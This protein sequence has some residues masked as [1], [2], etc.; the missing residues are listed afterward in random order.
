MSEDIDKKIEQYIQVRDILKAVDEKWEA[1]RKPLLEIQ[2]KLAG[3]IQSFM[4]ANNITG[5]LKSKAGTCYLLTS[6]SASLADPEAFMQYV[7]KTGSF[8]LMDRRANS[9]AVRDYVKEHN[10]TPPGC[11]LT[12]VCTVR[13]RRPT[14]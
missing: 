4:D 2:D 6:Y 11:N 9:T 1:Q 5:N 10:A 14:K 12:A 7:V 13:V 8:E 3:S